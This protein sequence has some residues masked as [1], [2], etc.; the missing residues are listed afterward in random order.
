LFVDYY[1]MTSRE[2]VMVRLSCHWA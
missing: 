2:T 1:V